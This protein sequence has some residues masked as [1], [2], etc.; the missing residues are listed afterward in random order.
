MKWMW[1]L[2]SIVLLYLCLTG[3]CL[4]EEVVVEL[5][6]VGQADSILITGAGKRVLIDAG[7]VSQ[8]KGEILSVA[9]QLRNRG[10]THLDMVFASHP[11]ADH[12]GGMQGVLET[13]S[14][15]AYVDNGFPHTSTMYENLMTV[16]EQKVNNENMKYIV[17]RHGQ[18]FNLGT[19]A[20]FEVLAPVDDK[21]IVGSRSDINSN[22]IIMKFVHGENCFL[23]MGDAEAETEQL[24]TPMIDKCPIIKLSHH[25][26]PHS[27]I[28][29][30]LDAAQPEIALISVGLA[31]KHGHP[32]AAVLQAF[33][34]R[35]AKIYRTDWMGAIKVVSDGKRVV[36]TTEK[37]LTRDELP[38]INVNTATAADYQ[39]L[40]GIGKTTTDKIQ[41]ARAN[42]PEN[43]TSVQEFL[44]N[45]K[46]TSKDAEHRLSKLT[47]YLAVDCNNRNVAAA[48]PVTA[49]VAVAAP[50][51]VNINV[52]DVA[53]LT[54]MGLSD[55]MARAAV[56]DRE[57]NGP[58]KSCKD[59]TRVKGIG[60]GTYKK[61]ANKCTVTAAGLSDAPVSAPVVVAANNASD[62]SGTVN[63]NIADVAQ[64]KAMGLSDKMASA[65]VADREANGPFKS[66]KDITRIKGIGDGTY[67][68]IAD[69]CSV[70]GEG[71]PDT[72]PQ[73]QASPAA[74]M[75][76]INTANIA[77][78][79]AMGLTQK[80]AEGA[81]ADREA[82][83][84]FKSCKDIT[85][86]KGIGDGTYKKITAVCTVQ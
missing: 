11:H 40:K 67:K 84:P 56:D 19:E 7:E 12:I 75:V 54:S 14:V 5:L 86:V 21:G 80:M 83:G 77:Q 30:F 82:N 20:Y 76:N 42:H 85:R 51:T 10:I 17:A 46:L 39:I 28:P 38:C 49:T 43:F 31:N 6:D 66:C 2:V 33:E 1:R 57:A 62:G 23:F 64:L 58:F 29:T 79:K 48:V 26:S 78:L 36:V 9:T 73:T 18:R 70:S 68:K 44:E 35:G 15:K 65:A 27:S 13:M 45:L 71:A 4:A 22:S 37:N 16:A 41:A 50:G 61:I 8:D 72:A 24:V 34:T 69:K 53:Q 52:A 47:D 59:I 3:V 55:K 60:D 25:G 63:I 32:G 74:G 81:V